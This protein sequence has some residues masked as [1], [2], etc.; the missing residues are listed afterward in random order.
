MPP[1][2]SIVGRS[3]AGKTT[4]IEKL[5]GELV[6]RGYRV[7][8]IKHAHEASFDTPGKDSWRHLKA[9][10]AAAALS[11]PGQLVLILPRSGEL[12]AADIERFFGEDYDLIL[13]EGFKR[14]DAPKIE[15]RR[16]GGEPLSGLARLVAVVTDGKIET[17][18]RQFSSDD[19]KGLADLLENGFI[20]PQAERLSLYVNDAPL[21]LTAFPKKIIAGILLGLVASLKGVG[22]VK[23]LDISLRRKPP[24]GEKL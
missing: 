15:V 22:I 11:T 17:K 6:G 2:V 24:P 10:S 3:E 7:A 16:A 1:V 5:V 20:R 9:G 21:T 19:V 12:S 13:T 18:A 23:S 4:L 14:A 8:T